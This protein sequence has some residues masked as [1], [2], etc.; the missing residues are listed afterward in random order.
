MPG[1]EL[2]GGSLCTI[3]FIW[4]GQN[5]G[6]PKSLKVKCVWKVLWAHGNLREDI[7]DIGVV[8]AAERR[9]SIAAVLQAAFTLS[10]TAPWNTHTGRVWLNPEFLRCWC[11]KAD[12]WRQYKI[13]ALFLNESKTAENC[14]SLIKSLYPGLWCFMSIALVVDRVA[15][16]FWKEENLQKIKTCKNKIFLCSVIVPQVFQEIIFLLDSI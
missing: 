4:K 7:T 12:K 6:G 15:R 10:F 8:G 3:S 9:R 1:E 5:F 16:C 2:L 14:S 11:T 13:N